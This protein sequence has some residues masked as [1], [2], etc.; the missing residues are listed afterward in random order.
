[1]ENKQK[2]LLVLLPGMDGTGKLFESLVELL[3]TYITPLVIGYPTTTKLSY[4]ALIKLVRQQI[5]KHQPYILLG[6]S[7]SG[8][9]AISLAAKADK[10]LKGVILSCTF[11]VNPR[12][13]LSKFGG[14][15]PSLPITA[16]S[17]PLLN[18]LLMANFDHP[19]ISQQ[20]FNVVTQVSHQ[21]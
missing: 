21:R 18:Q 3:P 1:M 13:F 9:I 7:F 20:L 10:Q 12:Q 15:V 19:E 5:P 14:L 2:I 6:E 17:K 4:Q 11:A 16:W 8:P